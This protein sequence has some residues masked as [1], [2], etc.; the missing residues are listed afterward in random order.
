VIEALTDGAALIDR[1]HWGRIRVGGAD[2]LAFL[3][4]QSTNDFKALQPG[5]GCDTVRFWRS[6]IGGG[7]GLRLLVIGLQQLGGFQCINNIC[8]RLHSVCHRR[9]RHRPQ[10]HKPQNRMQQVFVTATARCLDLATALV[11]DNQVMLLVSPS[12]REALL[13]RF[14]KF[15]FPSDKVEVRGLEGRRCGCGL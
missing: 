13:Q 6:G 3:H 10:N 5:Q 11:M 4:N 9:P 8:S 2:R 14:D 15:I 1:S 12:M 7:P